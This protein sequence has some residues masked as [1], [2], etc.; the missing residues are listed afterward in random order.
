M[1]FFLH[2]KGL[3]KKAPGRVLLAFL[4]AVNLAAQPNP[5]DWAREVS[6]Y[7]IFPERFAS[8]DPHNNP[9]RQSL[10]NPHAI[11]SD[12]EVTPWDAPWMQRAPWEE[13]M[14]PYFHDTLFHRR[15]GGDLQGVIDKLDYLAALGITGIYFNPLFQAPSLH[16]Y[17][18]SSFHHIDP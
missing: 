13:S 9:T 3:P 18:G 12:W 14:S 17:D 7:Q 4:F 10:P 1:P 2:R 16:K 5:P 15:Y 11:P 8:G 6:W